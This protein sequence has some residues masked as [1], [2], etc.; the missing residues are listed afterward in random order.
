MVSQKQ[1]YRSLSPDGSLSENLTF[2]HGFV[3]AFYEEMIPQF[4]PLVKTDRDNGGE[5]RWSETPPIAVLFRTW[6]R[7]EEEKRGFW[8]T[9]ITKPHK[10]GKG[11]I[12]M[13]IMSTNVTIDTIYRGEITKKPAYFGAG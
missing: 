7:G 4:P 12:I 11:Y 13:E 1:G 9:I 10:T 3:I 6:G 8:F 5:P 2:A